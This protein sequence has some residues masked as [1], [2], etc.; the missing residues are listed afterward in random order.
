M[1]GI[2]ITAERLLGQSP[3]EVKFST[4]DGRAWVRALEATAT[5]DVALAEERFVAEAQKTVA[6]PP[7]PDVELF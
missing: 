1:Q 2:P 3:L 7:T 6:A 5:K 4:H